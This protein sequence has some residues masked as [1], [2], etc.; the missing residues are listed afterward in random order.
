MEVSDGVG[1]VTLDHSASALVQC[2]P[3]HR[4]QPLTTDPALSQAM[5]LRQV[6]W[7]PYQAETAACAST[8]AL[9]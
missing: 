6:L 8:V 1:F 2:V 5:R 7:W 4:D 9:D 3:P